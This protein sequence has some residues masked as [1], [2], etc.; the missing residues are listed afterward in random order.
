M[1]GIHLTLNAMRKWSLKPYTLLIKPVTFNVCRLIKVFFIYSTIHFYRRPV[2]WWN[3]Y[4]NNLN[5]A[6]DIT[7]CTWMFWTSQFYIV[8]YCIES[9]CI[10]NSPHERSN[11]GLRK[12]RG[13]ALIG[14]TQVGLDTAYAFATPGIEPG[15]TW[16]NSFVPD[17]SASQDGRISRRLIQKVFHY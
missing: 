11:G 5:F 14:A 6:S 13:A 17:H 8:L 10:P 15:P 2:G 12:G 1:V 16:W 3:L 4:V 9:I 7:K